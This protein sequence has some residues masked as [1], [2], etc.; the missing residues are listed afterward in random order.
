[1]NSFWF[2]VDVSQ[3]AQRL[4][5]TKE[6]IQTQVVQAVE[7]LSA[8][9]HA[10]VIQ[11]ANQELSGYQLNAF[12]GKGDQFKN[13]ARESSK[14]PGIDVTSKYVRWVKEAPGLWVVEIDEAAKWIEEGR[15]RTFMGEDW[16]LL[17]PGKAKIAKDGS[18]YR[19]IPMPVMKGNKPKFNQGILGEGPGSD[20]TTA[21]RKAAKKAGV[22][23]TKIETDE[24][25]KP[26]AGPVDPT[27]GLQ[28]RQVLHKL[29]IDEPARAT[30]G[31]FFS[32]PRTEEEAAAVGL[33]PH[34]GHFHMKGM[35]VAQY[36]KSPGKFAKETVAFR[37][38]SS[39]HRADGRW[40]YPEIKPFGAIPAAYKYAEQEWEK[41][42]KTLAESFNGSA[43]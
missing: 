16:W 9:T 5:Q 34:K 3:V 24:S 22:S 10:F 38:I 26:I 18:S 41:I 37:V 42:L 8:S 7:G 40:Y 19:A 39:K 1:M 33:K 27:T 31:M 35:A 11:K 17:K 28:S 43:G 36:E 14:G 29:K 6:V 4:G 25:G 21:I 20:I 15:P 32:R 13:P 12:L 2:K 30:H 23:L